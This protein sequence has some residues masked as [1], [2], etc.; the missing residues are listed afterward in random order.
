VRRFSACRCTGG[1]SLHPDNRIA[2]DWVVRCDRRRKRTAH[3]PSSVSD[4]PQPAHCTVRR[5][6]TQKRT[7]RIGQHHRSIGIIVRT[8]EHT[9]PVARRSLSS[10]ASHTYPSAIHVPPESSAVLPGA[11][12]PRK[13][14]GTSRPW[15]QAQLK[16]G[17]FYRIAASTVQPASVTRPREPPRLNSLAI[18]TSAQVI[19]SPGNPHLC[20]SRSRENTR[21]RSKHARNELENTPV[22]PHLSLEWPFVFAPAAC[23]FPTPEKSHLS[24]Q[25]CKYSFTSGT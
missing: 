11:C 7:G 18:A 5:R 25:A 13:L 9:A 3:V 23:L 14:A 1:T 19:S 2:R 4:W 6:C 12:T 22:K 20:R 15:K 16:R 10:V 21:P 8:T 24:S 17:A